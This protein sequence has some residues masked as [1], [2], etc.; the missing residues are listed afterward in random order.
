MVVFQYSNVVVV[1]V[2]V[3]SEEGIF[4]VVEFRV[5]ALYAV[6]IRIGHFTD[7]L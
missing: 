1:V 6:T 3:L 4:L 7:R 2:V 5:K